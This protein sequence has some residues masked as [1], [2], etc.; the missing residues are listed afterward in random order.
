[1]KIT[2]KKFRMRYL[3]LLIAILLT[4]FNTVSC[5]LDSESEANNSDDGRDNTPSISNS[6]KG[7]TDKENTVEQ[8]E[9]PAE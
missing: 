7:I 5:S 2:Y 3:A 9:E 4:M 6:E 8:Q 1:M